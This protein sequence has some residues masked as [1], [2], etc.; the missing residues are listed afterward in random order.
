L[1]GSIKRR[2][3]LTK[4]D[5]IRKNWF[6]SITIDVEL[7]SADQQQRLLM[8]TQ[9]SSAFSSEVGTELVWYRP[10]AGAM[11][12]IV[13][14][15]TTLEY[16][17]RMMSLDKA[18]ICAMKVITEEARRTELERTQGPPDRLPEH[19]EKLITDSMNNPQDRI[20]RE[21]PKRKS[22]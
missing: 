10:A 2:A 15:K 22:D 21:R 3:R 11:E 7:R 17:L 8:D 12:A 16:T 19:I 9:A 20:K 4:W 18:K 14:C 1:F 13:I 5:D 6:V